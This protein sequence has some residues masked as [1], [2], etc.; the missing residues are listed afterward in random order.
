KDSSQKVAASPPWRARPN[1]GG[2]PEE[3][4]GPAASD[5]AGGS[6][7]TPAPISIGTGGARPSDGAARLGDAGAAGAGSGE[8]Q[9]PIDWSWRPGEHVELMLSADEFA[10]AM[11]ARV[12]PF[13]VGERLLLSKDEKVAQRSLERFLEMRFGRGN[14]SP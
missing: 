13:A 9:T 7:A 11:F 8:A 14:A 12:N 1:G 6:A 5:D 10:D 3:M 2:L 4:P